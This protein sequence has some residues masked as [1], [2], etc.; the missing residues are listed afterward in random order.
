M[1]VDQRKKIGTWNNV[2]T[3]TFNTGP[4]AFVK[5]LADCDAGNYITLV[6]RFVPAD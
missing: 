2:G 6:V 3:Y 4:A 1:N 5:Q